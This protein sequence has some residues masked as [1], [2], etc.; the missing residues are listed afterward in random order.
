MKR[1]LIG[2][3]ILI[4]FSG[5]AESQQLQVI[6]ATSYNADIRDGL[7]FKK[8]YWYIMPEK[9]P[10]RYYVELPHK[11]HRVTF[12][13]DIDSISF[14]TEYGG[15]Y[16]FIILL[17]NKDTCYTQLVAAPKTIANYK[18]TFR[19][20]SS[21]NAPDTIPFT[22]GNNNK[23]FI[24][25]SVNHS[26]TLS[27]QFDLGSSYSILKSAS[28]N[29]V[30]LK[31]D[32]SSKDKDIISSKNQ[33]DIAGLHWDSIDIHIYDKNMSYREDGLIG[34]S[35]FLDKIVE[36]NYDKKL[37][38]LHE[39][40]P[41][42]D[43]GFSRHEIIMDGAV[44]MIQAGIATKDTS[45]MGWF[46][47]DTGDSGNGWIDD[48]TASR[49]KLYRGSNKFFAFGDRVFVKLPE[50]KVA[51]LSF[52]NISAILAKKGTHTRDLSLLGNSILKRFNVILDN[53]NGYIYLKP[54]SLKNAPFDNT[55]LIIYGVITVIVLA[56]IAIII[57]ISRGIY[58]RKKARNEM[59]HYQDA[60][61]TFM[62]ETT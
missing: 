13:T 14:I 60:E 5:V 61:E 15:V 46:V 11:E 42:I 37:I 20:D 21:A 49:Y 23:I 6:K 7:H 17:N 4:W 56:I 57:L 27:F 2:V 45:F 54:N 30:A 10:D 39:T 25:G 34:N 32:S 47:F 55:F 12:Y 33:L 51:N 41:E 26:D 8:G 53:R 31:T 44:P 9:K 36:I 58:K 50:L 28:L 18:N 40:M 3:A 29:K 35:L 1:L 22:I 52:S 38:I 19:T 24:K 16:N 62:H 59:M 43:T 48:S